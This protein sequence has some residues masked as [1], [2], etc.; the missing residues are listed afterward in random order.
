MTLGGVGIL[1]TVAV[2]GVIGWVAIGQRTFF[3][4]WLSWTAFCAILFSLLV[5]TRGTPTLT[6]LALA[7]TA[8]PFVA[9]LGWLRQIALMSRAP[10]RGRAPRL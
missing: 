9:L 2:L 6:H 4:V 1:F 7:W 5:V 10:A 3:K 8:S